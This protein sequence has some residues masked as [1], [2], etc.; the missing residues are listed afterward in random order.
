MPKVVYTDEEIAALKA[1]VDRVDQYRYL[2][3]EK[4]LGPHFKRGHSNYGTKQMLAKEGV[5]ADQDTSDMELMV[6]DARAAYAANAAASQKRDAADDPAWKQWGDYYVGQVNKWR[7]SKG[8]NSQVSLYQDLINLAWNEI[9]DTSTDRC[10]WPQTQ[11]ANMVDVGLN[12]RGAW[13][14][15]DGSIPDDGSDLSDWNTQFDY[16]L[17]MWDVS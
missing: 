14:L 13:W 10:K 5:F 16:A 6:Q 17:H 8:I 11:D 7:A 9:N 1:E 2:P 3:A 15:F 12:F 4:V